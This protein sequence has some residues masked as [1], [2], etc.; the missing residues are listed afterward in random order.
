MKPFQFVVG[1]E[2]FLDALNNSGEVVWPSGLTWVS[3]NDAVARVKDGNVIVA[4]SPGSAT[5][6]G[7]LPTGGP[8]V[9]SVEVIESA[10]V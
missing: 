1:D 6:Y 9:I 5:F 10:D 2:G 4:V 7:G 8:V 3:D